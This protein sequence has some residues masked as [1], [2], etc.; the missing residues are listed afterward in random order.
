MKTRIIRHIGRTAMTL[1][2]L[3]GAIYLLRQGW[4]PVGILV[5]I[6]LAGETV[7]LAFRALLLCFKAAVWL[8][9]FGIL[10]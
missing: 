5:V 1:C 3:T 8:V 4:M 7:V 6:M 2:L 10:G 9:L